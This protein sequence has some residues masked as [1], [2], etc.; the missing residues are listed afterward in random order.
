VAYLPLLGQERAIKLKELTFKS[1]YDQWEPTHEKS[2]S[3]MGNYR[4]AMNYFAPIWHTLISQIDIDDL[5]E[6][7]DSCP[8]GKRT[9]E[10]MKALAGLLYKYGIPR[11]CIKNNLNLAEYIKVSGDSGTPKAALTEVELEKIR[12]ACD[13]VPYADYVYAHCYLGFRPS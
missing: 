8:K 9:K 4:A 6:C 1:L 10:N 2:K 3:T 5:Q 11:N 13:K 7:V 12:K